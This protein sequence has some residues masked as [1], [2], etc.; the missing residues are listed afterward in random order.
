MIKGVQRSAAAADLAA[1]L[2]A[3]H[4]VSRVHTCN[5]D[6]DYITFHVLATADNRGD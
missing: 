6:S 3:L 4:L 1:F 5:E 2:M